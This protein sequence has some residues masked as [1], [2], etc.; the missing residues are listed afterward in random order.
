PGLATHIIMPVPANVFKNI[1][2]LEEQKGFTDAAV[3]GGLEAFALRWA[4]Q[5]AQTGDQARGAAEA[6]AGALSGYARIEM[7]DRRAAGRRDGSLA[8]RV[9]VLRGVRPAPARLLTRLGASSVRAALLFCPF[10]YD[11]F[12]ALRPG[13]QLEAAV[14]Q[15]VVATIWDVESRT[16]R[17]GRP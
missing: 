3:A 4:E 16:T 15:T 9:R 5:A 6:I 11:D 13:A 7:G 2:R 1:L 12:S 10:R 17:N 14:T 8:S